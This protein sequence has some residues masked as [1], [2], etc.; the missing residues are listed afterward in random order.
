MLVE[1]DESVLLELS[2]VVATVLVVA[3]GTADDVEVGL[4]VLALVVVDKVVIIGV[5]VVLVTGTVALRPT[6]AQSSH[7]FSPQH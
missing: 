6:R 5:L 2:V 4:V 3:G 7:R 1:D